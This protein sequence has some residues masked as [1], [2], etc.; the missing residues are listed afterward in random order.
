MGDAARLELNPDERLEPWAELLPV[1]EQLSLARTIDDIAETVRHAARRLSGADGIT[2]VLRDGGFCH[3]LDEYAIGPLWKGQR[4]PLETCISGW[5]MLNNKT[6]VIPDI[7]QDERIPQA[8]Y[9]PT[10]VKSM[11]MT[12]VRGSDNPPAAIGAYWRTLRTP[13]QDEVD[14]LAALARSTAIAIENVKLVSSLENAARHAQQQAREVEALYHSAQAEIAERQKAE[15]KARVLYDEL[16]HRVKNNLTT[17]VAITQLQIRNSHDEQVKAELGNTQRRV[18][19][20]AALHS[21]MVRDESTAFL[22]SRY[23]QEVCDGI[24]SSMLREGRVTLKVDVEDAPVEIARAMSLGLIVNE[25]VANSARHA[26]APGQSGTIDVRF[27]SEGADYVLTIRDDGNGIARGAASEK[28]GLG[29]RLAESCVRQIGGTL[30]TTA[31]TKGTLC[32]VRAPIDWNAAA[33]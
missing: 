17:I 7:Y 5:C 30:E 14:I 11:V 21:R 28:K 2:F 19:T 4:F 12:P 3:Y 10:F 32:V 33:D 31:G 16:Q 22:F 6:A 1:I 9:R 25:L 8:A 23:V 29:L 27:V 20:V 24:K 13:S 15:I 18:L 26:F